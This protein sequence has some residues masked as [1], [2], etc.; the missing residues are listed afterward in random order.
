MTSAAFPYTIST[1]CF[2][3]MMMIIATIFRPMIVQAFFFASSLEPNK[4][5]SVRPT[6]IINITP[7]IRYIANLMNG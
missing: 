5:V 7:K 3:A 1:I 2:A 4:K 6:K